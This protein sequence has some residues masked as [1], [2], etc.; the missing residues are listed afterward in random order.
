LSVK[1]GRTWETSNKKKKQPRGGTSI[2]CEVRNLFQKWLRVGS[3]EL[4]VRFH[5]IQGTIEVKGY[6]C[7]GVSI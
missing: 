7:S 4:Q 3:E 2:E 6:L 1:G 5:G